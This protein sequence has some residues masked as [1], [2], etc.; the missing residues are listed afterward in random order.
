MPHFGSSKL[1]RQYLHDTINLYIFLFV[2]IHTAV[3]PAPSSAAALCRRPLTRHDQDEF[4][5]CMCGSA[6]VFEML[7]LLE[8]LFQT[9]VSA[10]L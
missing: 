7:L 4:S 5:F 10:S 2:K 9:V 3:V 8:L 1:R 6:A